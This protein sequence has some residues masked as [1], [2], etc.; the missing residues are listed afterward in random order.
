MSTIALLADEFDQWFE[1]VITAIPGRIGMVARAE[2]FKL[3]GAVIGGSARIQRGVSIIGAKSI[4]IGNQFSVDS[5]TSLQA[6]EGVLEIGHRVSVN[7]GA[8][9]DACDGGRIR[10]GDDVLIGPNV[11]IRAANHSYSRAD[12]PIRAQGHV[13]GTIVIGEDVWLSAD[14]VV[15]PGVTVGSHSV[16]GAGAV[17]TKDV[18]EWTVAGGVPAV[19]IARREHQ[20]QPVH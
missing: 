14:V 13:P 1:A 15:L 12:A 9:I 19:E 10:I 17:V 5:N 20:S 6:R 11:T 8:L 3:H 18:R 4:R 7:R 16:I 2:W